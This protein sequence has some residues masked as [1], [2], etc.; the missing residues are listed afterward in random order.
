[1]IINSPFKV[2]SEDEM[3]ALGRS[4]ADRVQPGEVVYLSG[5]LGVGKTTLARAFI[6]S[7]GFEGRI[8]SPS[9]GLIET[10]ATPTT[11]VAHLDL[12]R[13]GHPEEVA[14]L[15][16]EAY[17]GDAWVML[18]EWPERGLGYVPEPDWQVTIS[19]EIHGAMMAEG[20]RSVL[21]TRPKEAL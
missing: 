12:Y 16:L 15:G 13:L 4:L 10:Y 18:V 3:M 20:S 5:A 11:Q 1:M 2:V 9:Y 8:K 17:L 14:D 19:D 7:L 6:R 21:I